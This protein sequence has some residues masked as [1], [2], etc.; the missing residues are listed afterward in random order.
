MC[1]AKLR[2]NTRGTLTTKGPA[3]AN[4]ITRFYTGAA[5][6]TEKV[7]VTIWGQIYIYLGKKLF[8]TMP[9]RVKIEFLLVKAGGNLQGNYVC[10]ILFLF[11]L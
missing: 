2:R 3:N 1:L 11:Q 4:A 5:N 8:P 10:T 9:V 6:V 7:T